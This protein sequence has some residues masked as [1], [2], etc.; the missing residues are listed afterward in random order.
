MARSAHTSCSMAAA[1][2]TADGW[3]PALTYIAVA[4]PLELGRHPVNKGDKAAHAGAGVAVADG[5]AGAAEPKVGAA[6]GSGIMMAPS[7]STSP[8]H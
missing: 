2:A 6:A 3:D 1:Y 8:G 5:A 7:G 4:V